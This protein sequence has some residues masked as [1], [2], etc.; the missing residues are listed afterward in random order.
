MGLLVAT[1]QRTVAKYPCG[2]EWRQSK[3]K[4]IS[5]FYPLA[6]WGQWKPL[7]HNFLS[8]LPA[9]GRERGGERGKRKRDRI[10][11]QLLPFCW[12]ILGKRGRKGEGAAAIFRSSFSFFHFFLRETAGVA[13]A[14]VAAEG[15]WVA[16]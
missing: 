1:A 3:A 6:K 2:V 12:V 15:G 10:A 11:L 9:G 8:T 4:K 14:F 13:L 16:V 5:L 7:L